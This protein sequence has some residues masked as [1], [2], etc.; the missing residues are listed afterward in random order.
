M[1]SCQQL[2]QPGGPEASYFEQ[3]VDCVLALPKSLWLHREVTVIH[4]G[5]EWTTDFKNPETC[6][7]DPCC[8]GRYVG[9]SYDELPD[10]LRIN[11]FVPGPDHCY[12]DGFL[13]QIPAALISCAGL[14]LKYIILSADE[15]AA[16]YSKLAELYIQ[17]EE[18]VAQKLKIEHHKN[19]IVLEIPRLAEKV[20]YPS[21]K[22]SS[23]SVIIDLQADD[24]NANRLKA[25]YQDFG[26]I[27]QEES[28]KESAQQKEK[29][30]KLLNDYENCKKAIEN[31]ENRI[32]VIKTNCKI[33]QENYLLALSE[34]SSEHQAFLKEGMD[35]I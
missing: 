11:I 19:L 5:N 6:L 18:L 21:K 10:D 15:K 4:S 33:A 23:D 13:A 25:I 31:L 1:F 27:M 12:R 26:A 17:L 30:E 29:F 20:K 22:N 7:G 35:R 28:A 9:K 32:S 2:L 8:M 14:P 3:A 24:G 34:D 16:T